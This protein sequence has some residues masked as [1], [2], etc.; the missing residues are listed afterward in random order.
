M[1]LLLISL[2]KTRR[3]KA[4]SRKFS[5]PDSSSNFSTVD[6]FLETKQQKEKIGSDEAKS[7]VPYN[8]EKLRFSTARDFTWQEL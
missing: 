6:S 1:L 4:D 2:E 7:A 8:R 3:N 5:H